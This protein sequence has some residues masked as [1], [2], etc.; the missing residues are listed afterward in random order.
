[1]SMT[2]FTLTA[3]VWLGAVLMPSFSIAQSEQEVAA[4]DACAE[5]VAYVETNDDGKLAV[6]LDQARSFQDEEACREVLA[7]L[8]AKANGGQAAEPSKTAPDTVV[9]E[10]ATETNVVEQPAQ[11]TAV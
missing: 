9:V 4:K 1:M 3:A 10:G 11:G 8:T 2:R 7:K 6:T 5:L